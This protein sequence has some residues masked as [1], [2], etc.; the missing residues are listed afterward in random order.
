MNFNR[1]DRWKQR[2]LDD[3][4]KNFDIQQAKVKDISKLIQE[5]NIVNLKQFNSVE[6]IYYY[7]GN[8]LKEGFLEEHISMA[9]DVFIKDIHYFNAEDLSNNSFQ[10]FLSELS[11]NVISFS[12]DST[13][14]K[15]AKFLDWY[16]IDNKNIWYNL[17]RV[18][19]ARREYMNPSVLLKILD[20]FA[21]QN[22]GS[23][24]FYDLFQFLFW[25]DKF[26]KVNNSDFIS[27]G[28]NLFVTRQGYSQFYF[29]YYNKL[30]PRLSYRDS[31]FDLLRVIQTF[32]EISKYYMEVY[33]KIEEIILSRYEQLELSDATVIACG[34]AVAGCG[35]EFLFEHLEKFTMKNFNAL[36]KAGFREVV[37]AFVVSMNGSKEF[38]ELIKFKLKD[39]MD[40]FNITEMIYIVKC[41]YEKNMGDDE[42]YSLIEKAIGGVFSK[43]KD[44]LLEEICI[45]GE[46]ICHTDVFSREFQKLYEHVIA[47]RI[48]DIVA[49]K[50]ITRFLY[51]LFYRKGNCSVGLMDLLYKAAKAN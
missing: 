33:F 4:V 27:L 34:F 5:A 50:K 16:N 7:L 29:D 45:V 48:K 39:N 20:H 1:K 10:L 19:T 46:A 13:I 51:S 35:S 23:V 37:R 22:E 26:D 40:L 2:E 14:L 21:H 6:E 47:E 28:Y 42:F 32:S 24:E 38:F 15:T 11:K 17:E 12:N 30:L 8:L 9:L 36:D 3:I 43:P 44:V 41:Y 25:S 18:V 49:D 31:T